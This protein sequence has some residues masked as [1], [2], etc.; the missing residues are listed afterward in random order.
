MAV[1]KVDLHQYRFRVTTGAGQRVVS[2]IATVRPPVQ[3]VITPAS[4]AWVEV[5]VKQIL[6]YVKGQKQE[7]LEAD[8]G[9]TNLPGTAP[10][11]LFSTQE[12]FFSVHTPRDARSGLPT[13][14]RIY[15]PVTFLKANG[16]S[17]P[18]LYLALAANETLTSVI[19]DCYGQA[20]L[21]HSVK[22]TNASVA[23]MDFT[24]PDVRDPKTKSP[25]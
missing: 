21:A 24:Y 9:F 8:P 22:L 6:V 12:L 20:G 25:E 15:V 5:P 18:Q 10:T 16:P 4:P 13:G 7:E 3:Q 1:N 2:P 14:K 23:S 19:F 11:H 17:T